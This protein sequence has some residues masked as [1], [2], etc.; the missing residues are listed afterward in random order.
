M[1]KSYHINHGRRVARGRHAKG[2][3]VLFLDWHAEYVQA[4]DMTI[5]NGEVNNLQ[6]IRR[7]PDKSF[8]NILHLEGIFI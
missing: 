6:L 2:C 5:D 4:E 7:H 8:I 1:S 3:N